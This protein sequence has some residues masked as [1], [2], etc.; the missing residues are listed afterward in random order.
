MIETRA[1]FTGNRDSTETLAILGVDLLQEQ[2]VRTYK[3]TDEQVIDDPLVFLNQPD[4]IIVTHAFAKAHGLKNDSTFELATA[5]GKKRFTVRGQLSP[6]GPARA[7]GGDIAI[8]DIDGARVTFGKD[9]KVDR[10]DLITAEGADVDA[11]RRAHSSRRSARAIRSSGPASRSEAMERVI[12]TYQ[13]LLTVFSTLALIVGLFLVTNSVSI[14]VAERRREIGTLR[15][16]GR[17][18]LRDSGAVSQRSL[19]HGPF[20]RCLGAWLGRVLASLMVGLVTQSMSDQYMTRIEVKHLIFGAREVVLAVGGGHAAAFVAALIPAYRATRIGPLD[21]MRKVESA[22]ERARAWLT[23]S[24]RGWAWAGSS[25]SPSPRSITSS[26]R[27]PCAWL[28][29]SRLLDGGRG[30]PR[31]GDRHRAH[32]LARAAVTPAA[33]PC[34]RLASDN[35]LRSPRRTGSNVMTLMVGLILVTMIGTV[36]ISFREHDHGLVR[37]DCS[38]PTCSFRR[39]AR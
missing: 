23:R 14:S 15:A 39:S 35:L 28:A 5:N 31:A 29:R 19:R 1:Y 30:A 7:Y 25:S 10:A 24:R 18:A 11:R 4:S 20:R 13:A 37:P 36:N 6:E 17:H 34:S 27:A 38:A 2:S 12:A 32:P 16:L 26:S 22:T 9:G 8:M 21:A 3:T 33:E